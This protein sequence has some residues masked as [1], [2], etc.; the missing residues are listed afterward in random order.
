MVLTNTK[1]KQILESPSHRRELRSC[2][3]QESALR[4]FTEELDADELH[5]EIYWKKFLKTIENRVAKAKYKRVCDF[6]RFPLPAVQ[7]TDSIMGE[8]NKVFDGKN[9]YFNVEADRDLTR[10]KNWIEEKNLEYW[11]EDNAKEVFKNKPCSIVVVDRNATGDPYCVLIDSSRIIDAKEDKNCVIQYVAFLHSV[12]QDE[13][14]KMVTRFAVYDSE[15][16]HIFIKDDNGALIYD[17]EMSGTHE[18]GYCP[19]S[20]F[21]QETNNSKNIFKRRTAFGATISKLEDW[22]I[23][24]IFRNYVDHYAPFPVTESVV[25]KCA[26]PKCEDGVVKVEETLLE[27]E[28]KGQQ[29]TKLTK[30]KICDG[31][32]K[33]KAYVGPGTHI[34]IKWQPNRQLEDGSGK[35]RMIFPETDKLKYTPQKLDELELEIR[36][37]TVGVNNMLT[38]EAINEIQA[39]GS[40]MSMETVLLRN[41]VFLDKIYTFIVRTA[42]KMFYNQIDVKVEANYGTE[43][44]LVSEEDLQKRFENAKNIGL[45]INEITSIYKQLIETKYSNNKS[46]RDREIMLVDLQEYPFYS[47]EECVTMFENN[48]IDSFEISMKTNFFNFVQR[49]ERENGQITLFGLAIDYARRIETIKLEFE[50]YNQELIDKKTTRSSNN[51]NQNDE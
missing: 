48:I 15:N 32:G 40:F 3:L 44:Y 4:V 43:W 46:K 11:I 51:Q 37:K 5:K 2:Q 50:R 17:E 20:F 9:K 23:F 13:N 45:P 30:C 26:N 8:F 24:D 10:L 29:I 41:K 12:K 39:K 16:Y 18:I 6:I 27:G 38:K 35:F 36:Y 7:I 33:G 31:K 28:N 34:G 49:F 19:A 22:S 25:S 14:G 1:A 47:M 21:I 42:A